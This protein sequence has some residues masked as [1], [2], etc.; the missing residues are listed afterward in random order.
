ME[1]GPLARIMIAYAKGD[2]DVKQLVDDTLKKLDLPITALHSALGR[3]A[4][5]ALEAVLAAK[6]MRED[7]DELLNNI[8]NGNKITFDRTKWEPSS[9]PSGEAKGVGWVEAPRGAL[10]HWIVI[11]DGKTKNYQAV[12]PT[13]WN[14]SPRDNNGVIGAY[15]A[16]LVGTPMVNEEQPLELLRVIHSFDPCLACAV[17][18]TDLESNKQIDIRLG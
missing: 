13:T 5:R 6:W 17:H 1:V 9:W 14:A 7:M 4:A 8:K 15:E 12:V 2:A 16:S 10:G 3:T 11:E 18:L